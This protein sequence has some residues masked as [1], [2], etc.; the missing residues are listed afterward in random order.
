MPDEIEDELIGT[1]IA[2]YNVLFVILH[3][4]QFFCPMNAQTGLFC[5]FRSA[6]ILGALTNVDEECGEIEELVVIGLFDG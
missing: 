5:C 1:I 3:F 2:R 6:A 4:L